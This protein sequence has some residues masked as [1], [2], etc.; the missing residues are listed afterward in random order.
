MSREFL[1]IALYDNNLVKND[2]QDIRKS[3]G[4]R[5]FRKLR[6]LYKRRKRYGRPNKN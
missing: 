3:P 5:F 4:G 6:V 2:F 1:Y